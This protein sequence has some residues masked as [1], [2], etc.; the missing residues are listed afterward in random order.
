MTPNHT[1]F[2]HRHHLTQ[3]KQIKN[4]V[5]VNGF[6]AGLHGYVDNRKVGLPARGSK[7]GSRQGNCGL[8]ECHGRFVK[9]GKF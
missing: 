2:I 4:D 3:G 8:C 9:E 1:H 5:E 6:S 7:K